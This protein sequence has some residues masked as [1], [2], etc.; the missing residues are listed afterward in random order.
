[1]TAAQPPTILLAEDYLEL[2]QFLVMVL[3]GQGYTVIG[4]DRGTEALR[5]CERHAGPIHLLLTDIH[6]PE[7]DGLELARR[8]RARRPAMPVLYISAHP[9][10]WL[11]S[12]EAEAPKA[13]FLLKPFTIER[14]MCTVRE[15]LTP[16]P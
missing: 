6:M 8:I 10:P 11:P 9:T 4:V 12:Q 3:H 2:R 16:G 1:M 13:A 5:V 14:L 7:M 15:L